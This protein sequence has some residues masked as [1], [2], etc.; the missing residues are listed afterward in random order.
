MSE[1]RKPF[2]IESFYSFV[3]EGKLMGAKCNKCGKMLVPPKPMCPEC[4]SKDLKWRELPK[5][6][7]LLTYTIIHVSPKRFQ[8]LTPYAVGILE[9]E[10]DAQLP[11]MIRSVDLKDIT[12]GMSLTVGFDTEAIPEDWPQ[13]SR[14]FFK[15]TANSIKQ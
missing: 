5:R 13:W 3:K 12:V 11:G 8:H 10:N 9:L 4:F 14:Y 6:G 7:N 15:P 2:N 1:E